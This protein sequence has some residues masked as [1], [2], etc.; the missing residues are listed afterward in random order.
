[1]KKVKDVLLKAL[2]DIPSP[3]VVLNNFLPPHL[4]LLDKDTTT[5]PSLVLYLLSMFTKAIVNAFVNE[6]AINVK[7]AEPIGTMVAQVFSMKELQFIRH[8]PSPNSGLHYTAFG[9]TVPTPPLK[10][11]SVSLI[12]IFMCK[13][14]KVAP[15]LFGVSGGLD[16]KT[17]AGRERLG[18]RKEYSGGDAKAHVSESAHH[19]RMA[20][21]GAGYASVALRNFSKTALTNPW[22]SYHFWE[23]LSYI[24]DTKP[25]EIQPS[26]CYLL[27]SMLEINLERFLQFFGDEGVAALRTAF[28][29]FPKRLPSHIKDTN[30]GYA[31]RF[32][33]DTWKKEKNFTLE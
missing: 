1:M 20:G 30:A 19:S 29:E 4:S 24:V 31:V 26:H 9:G 23:S 12:S 21:I 5:V 27:K 10:P 8:A 17:T 13:I 11:T 25:A 2:H 15:I 6:C 3:P 33:A 28:I 22:P 14:H 16:E 18:W 7:S 32:M